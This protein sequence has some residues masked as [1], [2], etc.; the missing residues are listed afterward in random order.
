M[1]G[2]NEFTALLQYNALPVTVRLLQSVTAG[3]KLT[4][5][6]AFLSPCQV[7]YMSYYNVS[8]NY[9]NN[10][11]HVPSGLQHFRLFLNCF[12]I[13]FFDNDWSLSPKLWNLILLIMIYG[14]CWCNLSEKKMILAWNDYFPCIKRKTG[15]YLILI[16]ECFQTPYCLTSSPA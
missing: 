2:S 8:F 3:I 11:T 5:Q 14:T 1:P 9:W 15:F 7:K 16:F 6:F 4:I 12:L 13:N 10:F